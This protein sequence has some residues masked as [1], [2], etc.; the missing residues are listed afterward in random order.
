[1]YGLNLT[2]SRLNT[3][4]GY[5]WLDDRYGPNCPYSYDGKQVINIMHLSSKHK[6]ILQVQMWRQTGSDK[7]IHGMKVT[8]HGL[9]SGILCCLTKA[10]REG[11]LLVSLAKHVCWLLKL[12]AL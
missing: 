6:T 9:S 10:V 11:E 5:A 8:K 7:H 3:N 2:V 12:F 4:V 1:M